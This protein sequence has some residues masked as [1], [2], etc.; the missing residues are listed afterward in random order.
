LALIL[1]RWIL[2]RLV[3]FA[4]SLLIVLGLALCRGLLFVMA[5]V[6]EKFALL[7][8]MAFVPND[9]QPIKLL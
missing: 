8:L 3:S 9:Y 6:L 5:W 2:T 1:T 7:P 4:V